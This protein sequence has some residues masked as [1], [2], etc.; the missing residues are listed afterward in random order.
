MFSALQKD[1]IADKKIAARH[2][3]APVFPVRFIQDSS[4]EPL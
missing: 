3:V 1:V 2:I 4:F